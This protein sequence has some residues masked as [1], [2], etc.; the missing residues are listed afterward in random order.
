MPISNL[1]IGALTHSIIWRNHV[2]NKL[3]LVTFINEVTKMIETMS[4]LRKKVNN[5]VNNEEKSKIKGV[6]FI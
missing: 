3:N 5:N 1:S 2:R 4:K 6:F